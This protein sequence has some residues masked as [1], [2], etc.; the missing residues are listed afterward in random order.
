MEI[1]KKVAKVGFDWE[2]AAP[3][4]DK[5]AEEI[6][7]LHSAEDDGDPMEIEQEVG[8]LLFTVV[9]LARLL[10]VDPTLA[11]NGTNQKFIARF[12]ELESRLR[13]KDLRPEDADLKTMDAIWNQIKGE[14]R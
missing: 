7:E 12:Q 14:K 8:D 6:E 9:N 2:H 10:G 3:V 11:L 5:L 4:W 1:Q 13:H